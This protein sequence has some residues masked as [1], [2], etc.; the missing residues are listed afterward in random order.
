MYGDRY[1]LEANPLK[2]VQHNP[3]AGIIH[4]YRQPASVMSSELDD[5]KLTL[6]LEFSA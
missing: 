3:G 1:R 5:D 4:G 2:I 6:G